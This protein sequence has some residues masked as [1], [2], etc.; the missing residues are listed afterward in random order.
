MEPK[1]YKCNRCGK[2]FDEL[3][4]TQIAYVESMDDH[5][6]IAKEVCPYCFNDDISVRFNMDIFTLAGMI[7]IDVREEVGKVIDDMI[8]K[9]ELALDEK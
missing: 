5:V 2:E 9:G 6:P 4:V 8:A 3:L 7:G 1:L